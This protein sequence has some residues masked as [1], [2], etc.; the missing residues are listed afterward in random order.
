MIMASYTQHYQLHQWASTDDFLRTDFNT[1]LEKID[2]ALGNTHALAEEKCRI[3]VGTYTGDGT[4]S[5]FIDLGATPQAV[6]VVCGVNQIGDT[7]AILGGLLTAQFPDTYFGIAEGGFYVSR[8]GISA[9]TNS[10]GSTY[11]YIAFF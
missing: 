1:D 7:S 10:N 8:S 6:F 11:R 2:T 5:R 3:I 9:Q 4:A